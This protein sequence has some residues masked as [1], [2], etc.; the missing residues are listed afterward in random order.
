MLKNPFNSCHA[1]V[2]TALTFGTGVVV[3]DI[4][5]VGEVE[6]HQNLVQIGRLVVEKYLFERVAFVRYLFGVMRSDS[7]EEYVPF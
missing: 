5:T 1:G 6:I 3:R 2:E 4:Q 7:E